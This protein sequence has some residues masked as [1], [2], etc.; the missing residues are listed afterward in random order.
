MKS[1]PRM[2]S[3]MTPFPYT[4]EADSGVDVAFEMMTEKD[5]HHLPVTLGGELC[6]II[7]E[8]DVRT[9]MAL[10]KDLVEKV[11]VQ[12]ICSEELFKVD[13][14]KPLDEVVKEMARRR[15]GSVII[16][17]EDKLVGIFTTTDAC[18]CLGEFFEAFLG[19]IIEPDLA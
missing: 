18:N 12:D 9:A 1:I 17:R 7:S 16:T 4:I 14:D 19:G 11:S 2:K 13:L 10:G 3:V 8:R 5:F 15:V 6:G